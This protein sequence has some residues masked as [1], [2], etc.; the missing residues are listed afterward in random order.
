VT[1]ILQVQ[2]A[3]DFFVKNRQYWKLPFTDSSIKSL[4]N[5]ATCNIKPIKT[6]SRL[7]LFFKSLGYYISERYV[8]SY[9]CQSLNEVAI[10]TDCFI[11]YFDKFSNKE[12]P[13]VLSILRKEFL[14]FKESL[15]VKT[16]SDNSSHR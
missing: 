12:F 4:E 9:L 11:E 1:Q 15:P 2:D 6:T 16:L 3:I 10:F 14:D 13:H 8:L 5:Y 7:S